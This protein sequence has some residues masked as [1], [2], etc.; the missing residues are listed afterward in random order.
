MAANDFDSYGDEEAANYINQQKQMQDAQ[1]N[2]AMDDFYG[3]GSGSGDYEDE[4]PLSRKEL[5]AMA[6]EKRRLEKQQAREAKNAARGKAADYEE[7]YEDDD[8]GGKGRLVLKIILIILIVIL[9]AEIA[10]MAIRWVAPHSKAAEFIDTQLNHVIQLFTGD[11]TEYSFA[12]EPARVEPLEDKT[13]LIASQR[14]RNRNV[15]IKS[16]VYSADLK[17]DEKDD[18][19]ISDLVLSQPMTVV[20]WGKDE[21]NRPVYY[22]EQV[23][24]HII[25]FES[26][27]VNLR[28]LGDET[29]LGMINEDSELY[30]D[31]AA[32]KNK[33]MDG[34][35]TRLEIGEIRQAGSNYYVW[36]RETIGDTTKEKVYS[37]YPEKQF[38]MKMAACYES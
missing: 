22:D 9:A 37:M 7:D 6:K 33:K 26:N 38:V 19:D 14:G 17:Y 16:I 21:N 29:V 10:G 24:G 25:A 36:V 13:E 2:A 11:D 8:K 35:F 15:N 12:L 23:V 18:A 32:L 34:E 5:K 1:Q 31:T 3:D 20:E 4:E 30:K 28:N 27:R